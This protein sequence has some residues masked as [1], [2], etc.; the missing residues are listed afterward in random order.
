MH[1]S[2]SIFRPFV[3][4]SFGRREPITRVILTELIARV[5]QTTQ[6]YSLPISKDLVTHYWRSRITM[7]MHRQACLGMHQ[8][9]QRRI[10]KKI[11]TSTF[12]YLHEIIEFFSSAVDSFSECRALIILSLFHWIAAISCR[13]FKSVTTQQISRDEIFFQLNLLFQ[14]FC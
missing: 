11:C 1:K 10:K 2:G 13:F 9:I 3:L 7:A 14:S 6:T 12:K 4:E 8:R 5:M